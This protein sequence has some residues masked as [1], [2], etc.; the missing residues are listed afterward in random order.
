MAILKANCGVVDSG[1]EVDSE[2]SRVTDGS[3]RNAACAITFG[4]A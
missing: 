4:L 1:F 3:M 2:L